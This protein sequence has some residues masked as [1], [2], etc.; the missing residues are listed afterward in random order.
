METPGHI[1][2]AEK[3]TPGHIVPAGKETPGHIAPAGKETLDHTACARKKQ[4]AVDAYTQLDLSFVFPSK[5]QIIERWC[6][7][8]SFVISMNPAC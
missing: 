7:Q 6:L 4:R 5:L 1:V 8:L 2:P 3:E